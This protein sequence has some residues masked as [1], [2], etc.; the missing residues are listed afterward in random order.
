MFGGKGGAAG[1]GDPNRPHGLIYER[2]AD[3]AKQARR[4]PVCVVMV[5]D[6]DHIQRVLA[7]FADSKLRF[8]TTQVIVNRFPGSLRP[9]IEVEA[10]GGGDEAAGGK[11]K[12]GSKTGRGGFPDS[13]GPG[14]M[15]PGGMGALLG[16]LGS[17]MGSRGGR[18]G[19]PGAGGM[20]PGGAVG[21][22]GS[23]GKG[24]GPG[25]G[26]MMGGYGGAPVGLDTAAAA[27][28][29]NDRNVELVIYGIISLYERYPPRPAADGTSTTTTKN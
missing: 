28:E 27:G 25:R 22:P 2:Y 14:G 9:N 13:M 12:G 8:W 23:L 10:E 21:G 20:S 15:P 29:D 7:S 18:P 26:G 4:M 11:G 3:V 16:R 5:I 24:G 17:K 19:M 6:Q 1:G